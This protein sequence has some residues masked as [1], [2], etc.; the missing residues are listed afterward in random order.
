M[1]IDGT[2]A[3]IAAPISSPRALPPSYHSG[4]GRSWGP[5]P[6]G[7]APLSMN[8]PLAQRLAAAVGAATGHAGAGPDAVSIVVVVTLPALGRFELHAVVEAE[9]LTLALR[10]ETIRA[11]AWAARNRATLEARMQ[12]RTGRPVRLSVAP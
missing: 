5:G 6:G 11:R 10:G 9:I 4:A 1:R 3:H 2:P 8:C 7:P 12:A